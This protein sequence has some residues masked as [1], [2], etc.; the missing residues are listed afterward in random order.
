MWYSAG[1]FVIENIRTDSLMFGGFRIA[2]IVSI[3]LFCLGAFLLFSSSRKGK[4]ENLYNSDKDNNIR[5]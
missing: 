5:F 2:Q 3:L 4:F 1:R